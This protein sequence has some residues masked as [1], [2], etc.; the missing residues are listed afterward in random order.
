MPISSAILDPGNMVVSAPYW[1]SG[2]SGALTV[3]AANQ[4]VAT[5]Q[6]LGRVD[7]MGGAIIPV[8]IRVSQ[9]SM[10]FILTSGATGTV[11]FEL[12]K[13]TITAQRDTGGVQ[14]TPTARKSTGYQAITA[15][16]VN[17]YMANTG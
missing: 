7:P 14:K 12:Y 5:L 13:A 1:I 3:P 16:E 2:K 6:N 17:L 11:A 4:P 8:P 9:A 10:R 15:A